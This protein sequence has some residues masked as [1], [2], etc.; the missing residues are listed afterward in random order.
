MQQSSTAAAPGRVKSDEVLETR[1]F[2][3]NN[4]TRISSWVCPAGIM[5]KDGVY[6]FWLLT[7]Q[8][9]V[10]LPSYLQVQL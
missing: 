9:Q 6:T 7:L 4:L 8:S 1:G 3:Y 2:F 10:S 5:A